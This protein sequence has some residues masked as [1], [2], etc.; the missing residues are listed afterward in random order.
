L[1]LAYCAFY[2]AKFYIFRMNSIF[3][4]MLLRVKCLCN[5]FYLVILVR[6]FV[7][8]LLVLD[9]PDSYKHVVRK[10]RGV[11]GC[12]PLSSWFPL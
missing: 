12:V 4:I 9:I 10:K 3:E 8:Y 6:R 2:L 11:I 5:F 7:D 1:I